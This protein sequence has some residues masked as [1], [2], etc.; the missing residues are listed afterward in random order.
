V[1]RF[2]YAEW[3]RRDEVEP[4]RGSVP[5]TRGFLFFEARTP[6]AFRFA[7]SDGSQISSKTLPVVSIRKVIPWRTVVDGYLGFHRECHRLHMYTDAVSMTDISWRALGI[8]SGLRWE[9]EYRGNPEKTQTLVA[10]LLPNVRP[11]PGS[12]GLLKLGKADVKAL[13]S[14]IANRYRRAFRLAHIIPLGTPLDKTLLSF[15]QSF[16]QTYADEQFAALWRTI[17]SAYEHLREM[18]M[19]RQEKEAVPRVKAALSVVCDPTNERIVR[20]WHR[21]RSKLYHSGMSERLYAECVC[22]V[23]RV[24]DAASNIVAMI[25]EESEARMRRESPKTR[26]E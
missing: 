8:T 1:R 9:E 19:V 13:K 2:T 11:K 25:V 24:L 16:I 26:L 15:G 22:E 10:Q 18:G 12:F 23:N 3:P 14:S 21:M 4:L 7:F 17:E 20:R 5:R 6:V